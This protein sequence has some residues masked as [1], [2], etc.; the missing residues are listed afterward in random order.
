MRASAYLAAVLTAA[1]VVASAVRSVLDARLFL[2]VAVVGLL[3][4]AGARAGAATEIRGAFG[5]EGG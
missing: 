1:T 4:S 3:A 5:V 2:W